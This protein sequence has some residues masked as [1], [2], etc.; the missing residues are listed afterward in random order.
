MILQIRIKGS[1]EGQFQNVDVPYP[2]EQDFAHALN[3]GI[4]IQADRI[5]SYPSKERG[6]RVITDRSGIGITLGGI[7]W[8]M[9]PTVTFVEDPDYE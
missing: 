2:T 9:T 6:V 8:Y 7:D 1:A 4:M 5:K 3:Q